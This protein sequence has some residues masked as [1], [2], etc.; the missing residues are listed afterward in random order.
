MKRLKYLGLLVLLIITICACSSNDDN[1]NTSNNNPIV[2]TWK[3]LKFVDVCSSGSKDVYDYSACEQQGRLVISSNGT[4]A[5]SSFFDYGTGCEED[6][7]Y[8]GT[9]K[10]NGNGLTV[11]IEG[12]IVEVT[13]LEVT[14]NILKLGAYEDLDFQCIDNSNLSHYY[15]EYVRVK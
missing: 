8:S 9:W 14:T 7:N 10:S 5:E 1:D 3:P 11:N 12:E 4:F 6:D 15:T 13:F 2:G